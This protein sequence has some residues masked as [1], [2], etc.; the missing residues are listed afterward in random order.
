[1]T[2]VFILDWTDGDERDFEEE[3]YYTEIDRDEQPSSEVMD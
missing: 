2:I 1:M 3:F